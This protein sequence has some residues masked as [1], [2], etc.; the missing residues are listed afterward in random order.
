M[1]S[2][3]ITSNFDFI[4]ADIVPLKNTIEFCQ[5][6]NDKRYIFLK[7]GNEK[8]NAKFYNSIIKSDFKNVV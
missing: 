8:R 2:E 7:F 4:K 1:N 6:K 3:Q 5:N